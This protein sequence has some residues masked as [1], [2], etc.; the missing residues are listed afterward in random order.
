MFEYGILIVCDH[1]PRNLGAECMMSTSCHPALDSGD[2]GCDHTLMVVVIDRNH[3]VIYEKQ[4]HTMTPFL[5][6]CKI[7]ILFLALNKFGVEK[8]VEDVKS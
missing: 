2:V 8:V 5:Q 4:I 7:C 3:D 1:P 6:S